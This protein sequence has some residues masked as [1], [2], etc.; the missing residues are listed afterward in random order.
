[1]ANRLRRKLFVPECTDEGVVILPFG[2]TINGTTHPDALTG[3]ITAAVRD[4]A[5]EFTLTLD[6]EPVACFY[7]HADVSSVADGVDIYGKVDWSTAATTGVIKVRFM[8]GAT[9]TDP[10]DDLVAGGF[11]LVKKTNRNRRT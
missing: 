9:Q 11:L 10:T 7:G 8:T 4:E 6:G 2:F 1:M 5:G 3:C